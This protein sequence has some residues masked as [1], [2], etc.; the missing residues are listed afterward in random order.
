MKTFIEVLG[1]CAQNIPHL[2]LYTF[3]NDKS[4]EV[5][6]LTYDKFF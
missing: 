4:E 1:S 2:K 5:F 3:L 6:A